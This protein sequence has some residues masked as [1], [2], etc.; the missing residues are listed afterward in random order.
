MIKEI[1]ISSSKKEEILNINDKVK[2]VVK[3]SKVKEGLCIVYILHSTAAIIIN[4]NWD[5]NIN[6]DIISALGKLIPKGKWMH[7][8][9]DGNGAAHIKAA[10][11]GPSESIIIKNSELQLGKWQDIMLCDFDGPRQRKV[12]VKIIKG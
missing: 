5:P 8:K 2:K 1:S 10:I 3:E 7:D 9:V 6:L 11:I 4:E 12:L